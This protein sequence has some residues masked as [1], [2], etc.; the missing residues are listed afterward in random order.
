M[1]SAM[2]AIASPEAARGESEL[3]GSSVSLSSTLSA[4]SDSAPDHD[5]DRD[6]ASGGEDPKPQSPNKPPSAQPS[7]AVRRPPGPAESPPALLSQVVA[8]APSPNNGVTPSEIRARRKQL[9]QQALQGVSGRTFERE[10]QAAQGGGA[11]QEEFGG[12]QNVTSNIIEL[13]SSVADNLTE[14][15]LKWTAQ[16]LVLKTV[17]VDPVQTAADMIRKASGEDHERDGLKHGRMYQRDH[18]GRNT[19]HT[20]A[21]NDVVSQIQSIWAL[22]PDMLRDRDYQ[23]FTPAHCAAGEGHVRTLKFLHHKDSSLLYDRNEEGITPAH[24][25]ASNGQA[26]IIRFLFKV[27]PDLTRAKR[28]DGCLPVHR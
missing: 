19:A 8:N 9:V 17:E 15:G 4:P 22:N 2:R 21:M 3:A 13:F 20:A 16:D 24:R 14:K 25:A 18:Y 7:P 26:G 6:K 1:I 5:R 10:R 28:G 12:L 11:K 23:G 27:D